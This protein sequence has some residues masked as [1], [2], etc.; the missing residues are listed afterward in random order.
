MLTATV[1][2]NGIHIIS[3]HVSSVRSVSLGIWVNAGSRQDP[4]HKSGMAHFSEHMLFKGTKQRSATQI[5][6]EIDALGGVL[7]AQ[8]AKEYTVYYVKVLDEHLDKASEVLFDLFLNS[9]FDP[10]ELEKEKNVVLQEIHMTEDT[11]DDFITEL[12]ARTFFYDTSL[13]SSILGSLDSVR[14]FERQDLLDFI[15]HTYDPSSIVIVAVGNVEHQQLLDLTVAKFESLSCGEQHL[16]Q[17]EKLN[18]TGTIEAHFRE[19]EQV[20]FTLGTS[21]P[22]MS[23]ERRWSYIV[24]NTILGGSMSSL[25]FQEIRENLSLVYSIYSYVS[26]FEDCGTMAVYAGTTPE[27][28]NKTL[29]IVLQQMQRLK[30]KDLADVRLEDIKAQIK[31]NL[32]LSRESTESRMASIA[33]NEIYYKREVSIEEIIEKIQQ[34][35][36]TDLI[37][38]ARDIFVPEKMTLVTLG[39]IHKD[40]LKLSTL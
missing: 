5:A 37:E 28:I 27:N 15:S 8:T 31:G 29:E 25:L 3:E 33:K 12:F 24:L 36:E 39:N 18:N 11:P 20:H 35:E 10:E 6:K 14:S 34:V 32:L 4:P 1:L 40:Q 9:G 38:L 7:N 22:A 19:L 23:D 16:K 26:A 30:E 13:G 21:G 2:A 17:Q